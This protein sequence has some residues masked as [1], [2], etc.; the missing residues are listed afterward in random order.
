MTPL[1]FAAEKG[2]LSVVEYLVDQQAD[3]NAKNQDVE[4]LY[5]I[6]L[7]FIELLLMVILVLLN[8]SLTKKLN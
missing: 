2:H 8:I 7:L 6:I 5:L 1:H 3:I 4:F